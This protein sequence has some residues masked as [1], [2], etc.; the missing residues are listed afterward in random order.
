MNRRLLLSFITILVTILVA[1]AP[2]VNLREENN[3][4]DTSLLSGEP[5]EAPCWNNI[6]PG[7]TSYRDAKI[8]V[9]DD[10]KLKNVTEPEIEEGQTVKAFTFSGGDGPVCCQLIAEDGVTIN[11][12]LLFLSPDISL[13]EI[14]EKYGDPT[15]VVGEAVNEEQASLAL[16]YPDTPM[17]LYAFVA[18]AEKG[19][20]TAS[21]EIIG[22]IYMT[23]DD[24]D[25][26]IASNDLYEWGGYQSFADYVD[27]EYDHIGIKDETD[28]TSDDTSDSEADTEAGD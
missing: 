6:T 12:M 20:L 23:T 28:G 18:G 21:S 4:K 19:E 22:A 2:P 9:E 5:C 24:V 14:I 26:I 3:L 1:C 11:S 25:R 7:E 15:Y 10:T 8:I 17:I 16:I 27:G 13:G